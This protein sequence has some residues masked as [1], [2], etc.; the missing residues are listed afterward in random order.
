MLSPLIDAIVTNIACDRSVIVYE[1]LDRKCWKA[2]GIKPPAPLPNRLFER[3]H[4]RLG[5]KPGSFGRRFF[6]P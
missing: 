4:F 6:S 3:E 5:N 2:V 1:L